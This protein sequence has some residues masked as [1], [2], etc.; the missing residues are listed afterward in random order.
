MEEDIGQEI[1]E[2]GTKTGKNSSGK[3]CGYWK[4]SKGKHGNYEKGMRKQKLQVRKG[5]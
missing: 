4:L 5:G 2:Y 1:Y 3:T